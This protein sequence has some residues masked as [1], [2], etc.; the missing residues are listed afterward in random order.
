MSRFAAVDYRVEGY[1]VPPG[2]LDFPFV[3]VY[4]GRAL[5]DGNTYYDIA[6][7]M[8][9]DSDFILRRITGI[10]TLVS[11]T[12]Q[13]RF[14]GANGAYAMSNP[15]L[16]GANSRTVLP[17]RVYP[18]NT[19]I[20]FDLLSVARQS[21]ACSGDTIFTAFLAFQ[22]VK[23]FIATPGVPT[24][25]SAY[26][27]REYKWGFPIDLTLAVFNGA[28][29]VRFIVPINDYDFELQRIAITYAD[30]TAVTSP[31]F[32]VTLFDPNRHA[33]SN[34]PLNVDFI[35]NAFVRFASQKSVFPVPSIL[36]P[37]GSQIVFDVSSY[38]CETGGDQD[39]Q[40]LFDGLQ[41]L[42]C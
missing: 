20:R 33:F 3:Y 1:K 42:P 31:D 26:Q 13:F 21:V 17:E 12:G 4:D 39:Y 15:V 24:G 29:P 30:G 16:A 27:Y 22:G 34:L 25:K 19:A 9:G 10:Q 23:R 38:L 35:N 6:L 40:I 11:T 2:Y 18:Y 5:T 28:D 8:Q 41:R 32:G 14:R 7:P 36:Y 37:T